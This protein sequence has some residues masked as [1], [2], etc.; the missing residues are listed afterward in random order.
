MKLVLMNVSH[1]SALQG[2]V[3]GV[4]GVW[5][6]WPR[7]DEY[8]APELSLAF[9]AVKACLLVCSHMALTIGK[10]LGSHEIIGL[11]SKDGVGEIYREL[12]L[13]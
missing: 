3:D 1:R 2:W 13:R 5:G 8:A 9:S 7:S 11:L 6:R 12:P 10:Q 4:P